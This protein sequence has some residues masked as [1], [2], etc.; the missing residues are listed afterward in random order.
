MSQGVRSFLLDGWSQ[1]PSNGL[2]RQLVR[3]AESWTLPGP[4]ES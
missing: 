2:T 1:M 3:N 4:T